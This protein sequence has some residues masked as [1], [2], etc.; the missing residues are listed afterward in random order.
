MC[1]ALA[2]CREP[3]NMTC[4]K[5][6]AKPVLPGTSCFDPTS[7]QRLTATTGARWSSATTTRRPLSRCWSLKTTSGTEVGT[8]GTSG[9]GGK[10][11]RI[12][13]D[14]RTASPPRPVRASSKVDGYTPAMT[15]HSSRRRSAAVAAAGVFVVLFVLS[16]V[17]PGAV[18]G[19]SELA[20]PTPADKS[21]ATQPV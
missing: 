12:V 15:R 9:L 3:W 11:P 18:L 21:T 19:H 7:Y 5:R 14:D 16:A 2:T 13:V 10:R 4:S 8:R 20:T 1:S 6:C 17:L